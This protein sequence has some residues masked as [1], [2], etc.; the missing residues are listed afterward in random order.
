MTVR[1]PRHSKEEFARRGDEIYESLVRA[2][3][4]DDNQGKIVAG[5]FA[6]PKATTS[7]PET[8][9]LMP[10]KLLLAIASKPVTQ[11]LK[12]GLSA[13]VPAMFVDLADAQRKPYDHRDRQRGF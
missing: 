4:E 2:Q 10:V 13:L 5:S 9:K 1:Q 7:K 6:V 11:T 3:V 12:S 8:L